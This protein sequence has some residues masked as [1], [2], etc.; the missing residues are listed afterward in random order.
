MFIVSFWDSFIFKDSFPGFCISFYGKI[1]TISWVQDRIRKGLLN[2]EG[3]KVDKY[4]KPFERTGCKSEREFGTGA[5]E[6]RT[7]AKCLSELLRSV[8][9]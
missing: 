8:F 7:Q 2:F 6:S 5:A 4:V 1:L 3:F 9:S